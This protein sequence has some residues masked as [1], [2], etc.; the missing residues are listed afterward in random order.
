MIKAD[1]PAVLTLAIGD[2]AN[3]VAM[4]KEAHV[5]VGIFGNEGLRAVQASDFAIPEFRMLH[6]LVLFH[7][8]S[9]YLSV[10]QF[11]LYFFYKNIAL[12]M[13]QYFFAYFSGYSAMTVFDDFYIQLYNTFF[14]ATPPL[15]LAVIYWD[16]MT[17]LDG[18][19]FEAVLAK[20]YYVG[21]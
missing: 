1:D 9:R 11:I 14:T 8:R 17:D 13:P 5:G 4:I 12:S 18:P 19:E 20:L 15:A 7:G 21:Q 16:L 3:D 10:T 2:G 6:R